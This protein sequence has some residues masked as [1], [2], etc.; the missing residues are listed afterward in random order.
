M[1]QSEGIPLLSY[2]YH[3]WLFRMKIH[4][5]QR[6][7]NT[8]DCTKSVRGV[9]MENNKISSE[10]DEASMWQGKWVSAAGTGKKIA[11]SSAV[12]Q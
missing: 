11:V 1:A 2:S 12:D 9:C 3:K 4:L 5:K 8:G 6:T 10:D 7:K